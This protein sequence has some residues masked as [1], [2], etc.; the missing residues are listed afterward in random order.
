VIFSGL[1]PLDDSL[2]VSFNQLHSNE[3]MLVGAY[4]CSYRHGHQALSFIVDGRVAVEDM[5]SHRIP[6]DDLGAALELVENRGGMKKL[7]YP[8]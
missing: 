2:P 5:I 6:L 1:S 4:G 8:A 7:L 3:Q